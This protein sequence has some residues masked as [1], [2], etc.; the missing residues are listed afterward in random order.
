MNTAFLNNRRHKAEAENNINWKADIAIIDSEI[1]FIKQL[2]SSYMFEPRT[3]ILFDKFLKF[4]RS[5]KEITSDLEEIK[6]NINTYESGLAPDTISRATYHYEASASQFSALE[7]RFFG[8]FS[9][10]YLLKGDVMSYMRGVL[11]NTFTT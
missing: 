9:A 8:L 2:L 3:K 4:K 10:F 5:L 1:W 7:S 11:N 6:A